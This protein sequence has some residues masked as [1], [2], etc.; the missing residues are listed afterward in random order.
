MISAV[1]ALQRL[2]EGNARFAAD[3]RSH[4]T[5]VSRTHRGDLVAGQEPFA[6][7][8]GCSDSRV[9]AEM[10]FYQRFGDLFVI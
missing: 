4:A 3:I 1:E 7:I 2:R 10:V 5:D 9:P 6:I 8:F